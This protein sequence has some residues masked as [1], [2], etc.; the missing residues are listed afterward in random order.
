MIAKAIE[1]D[2]FGI[3]DLL[4]AGTNLDNPHFA[5]THAR[6]CTHALTSIRVRTHA[7]MHAY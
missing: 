6:A 7:R 4:K 2:V 1:E 3:D 5:R